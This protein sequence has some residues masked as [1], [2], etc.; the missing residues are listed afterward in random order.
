MQRAEAWG[1]RAELP[2]V[3]DSREDGGAQSP[4]QREDSKLL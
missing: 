2:S 4:S 1:C 3:P